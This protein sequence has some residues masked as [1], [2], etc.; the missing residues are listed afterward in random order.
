MGKRMK[1]YE[2]GR[3]TYKNLPE[4]KEREKKQVREYLL[5]HKEVM[6]HLQKD[7]TEA[8]KRHAEMIRKALENINGLI[9]VTYNPDKGL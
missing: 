4:V 8:D 9:I 2:S 7:M 3:M 1:K 5:T 6:E